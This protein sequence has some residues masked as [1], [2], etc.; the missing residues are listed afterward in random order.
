VL[1]SAREVTRAT[2]SGVGYIIQ[3]QETGAGVYLIQGGFNGGIEGGCKEQQLEPVSEPIVALVFSIVLFIVV[4]ALIVALINALPILVPV[5]AGAGIMALIFDV[6][7]AIAAG[8]PP[9]GEPWLWR[10]LF[11]SQYG[12]YQHG[13]TYPGDG[14]GKVPGTCTDEQHK[15]L[16]NP[17]TPLSG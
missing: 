16:H 10:V 15:L 8:V 17:T 5:L 13:P 9:S 3:D 7:P 14:I 1:V 4:V 12:S 6:S 2:W 11:G